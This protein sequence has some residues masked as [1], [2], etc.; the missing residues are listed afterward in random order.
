MLN[1]RKLFNPISVPIGEDE[2]IPVDQRIF[3]WG[4][5]DIPY[6]QQMIYPKSRSGYEAWYLLL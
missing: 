5:S 1:I 3:M 4:D 6:L 2:D